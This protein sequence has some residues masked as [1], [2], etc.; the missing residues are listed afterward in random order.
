MKKYL[1]SCKYWIFPPSKQTLQ[2]IWFIWEPRDEKVKSIYPVSFTFL[3]VTVFNLN[4]NVGQVLKTKVINFWEH[5]LVTAYELSNSLKYN[6]I[7]FARLVW[8]KT[9]FNNICWQTINS[10]TFTLKSFIFHDKKFVQFKE[11]CEEIFRGGCSLPEFWHVN[12]QN[13]FHL[14]FS[15]QP[16][17]SRFLNNWMLFI[18]FFAKLFFFSSYSRNRTSPSFK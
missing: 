11:T 7:H 15:S 2:N 4:Q 16:Q 12:Y 9:E 10:K 13:V 17:G 8:A 5:L 1:T 6:R 14:A 3:H 18:L